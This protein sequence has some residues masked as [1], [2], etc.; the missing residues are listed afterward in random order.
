MAIQYDS[1][2]GLRQGSAA[3]VAETTTRSGGEASDVGCGSGAE[4]HSRGEVLSEKK[5]QQVS[6]KG[7]K[8]K[9]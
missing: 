8:L 4:A 6:D 5:K 7:L 2:V 3:G 1:P 9:A